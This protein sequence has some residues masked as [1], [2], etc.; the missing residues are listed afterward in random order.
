MTII[1]IFA[2]IMILIIAVIIIIIIIVNVDGLFR[3]DY[4]EG[5]IK[6]KL[7]AIKIRA[8]CVNTVLIRVS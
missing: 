8:L 1:V 2:I 4:K 6:Y 5:S 7:V 3:V